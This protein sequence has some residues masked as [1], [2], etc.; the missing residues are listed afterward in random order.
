MNKIT[1]AVFSFV[2]CDAPQLVWNI[3]WRYEII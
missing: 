2:G 1:E 3:H